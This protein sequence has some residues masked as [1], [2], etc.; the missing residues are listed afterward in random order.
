[1]KVEKHTSFIPHENQSQVSK[2]VPLLGLSE[3]KVRLTPR[4]V[5]KKYKITKTKTKTKLKFHAVDVA[6][7]SCL[8]Q[9]ECELCGIVGIR[10]SPSGG[11]GALGACGDHTKGPRKSANTGG[12]S[13]T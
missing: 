3:K 13:R 7:N 5:S 12:T 6:C 8:P 1:M 4:V 9:D 11:A 2:I 10:G